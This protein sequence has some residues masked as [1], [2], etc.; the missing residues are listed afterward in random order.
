MLTRDEKVENLL[1]NFSLIMMGM[2]EGVF[3]TMAVG[4]V[5][6]LSTAAESLGGRQAVRK[7]ERDAEV[8]AKLR[9]VF[10]DLRKEVADGFAGKDEKFRAFVKNPAF[11]R[12]VRIVESNEVGLP[13]LTESLTDEDLAGYVGLI[14]KEDPRLARMMTELG[15]WQ[16]TTPRFTR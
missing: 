8:D 15:E 1:T 13:K 6:A 16:K 3:T 4:L 12:G 10:A 9:S 5:D 7:E 11:D 14:Q 2:F